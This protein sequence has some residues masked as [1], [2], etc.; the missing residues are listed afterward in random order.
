MLSPSGMAVSAAATT[1]VRA[2]RDRSDVAAIERAIGAPVAPAPVMPATIP[3]S[4]MTAETSAAARRCDPPSERWTGE[5]RWRTAAMIS[6]PMLRLKRAQAIQTTSA[7]ALTRVPSLMP[8]RSTSSSIDP[9]AGTFVG[10]G[11]PTKPTNRV[12]TTATSPMSTAAATSPRPIRADGCTS[13][14]IDRPP[15][16]CGWR[17]PTCV[18]RRQRRGASCRARQ[19]PSR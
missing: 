7:I 16:R 4:A 1:E 10:R 2:A 8:R 5:G 19:P 11:Q 6:I 3:V 17:R 14:L 9:N 18:R 15:G 12:G 13:P